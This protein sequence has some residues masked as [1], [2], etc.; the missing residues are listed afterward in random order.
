METTYDSIKDESLARA[1]PTFVSMSSILPI[2]DLPPL[3]TERH[4]MIVQSKN[5]QQENNYFCNM[6]KLGNICILIHKYRIYS[7]I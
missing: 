1:C 4:H 3:K 7:I 5:N 2:I 6:K